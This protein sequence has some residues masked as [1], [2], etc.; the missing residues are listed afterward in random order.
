MLFERKRIKETQQKLDNRNQTMRSTSPTFP[1]GAQA[2]AVNL[3]QNSLAQMS[4][5]PGSV[6][7]IPG[8]GLMGEISG[9]MTPKKR[10]SQM[11]V[12]NQDLGIGTSFLTEV[13]EITKRE[14][15]M[16]MNLNTQSPPL[17]GMSDMQNSN[18]PALG[19]TANA[20]PKS[21]L[22]SFNFLTQVPID[23]FIVQEN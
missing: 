19:F 9:M 20:S 4:R 8:R 18:S 2:S 5:S 17:R 12:G 23:E 7:G 22:V 13:K 11:S 10:I 21:M 6:S 14:S 15:R 16:N 3:N 1:G